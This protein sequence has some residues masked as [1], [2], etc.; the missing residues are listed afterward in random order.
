MG[1]VKGEVGSVKGE[2][3]SVKGEVGSV[4]G[5][6]GTAVI[7]AGPLLQAYR[8]KRKPRSR[9]FYLLIEGKKEK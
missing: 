1:S 9:R 8:G 6:E 2:V 7:A 3:G 5:E 4:K